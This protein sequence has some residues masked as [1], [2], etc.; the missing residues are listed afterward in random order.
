[1]CAKMAANV[2]CPAMG[3]WRYAW[4]RAAGRQSGQSDRLHTE[5]QTESLADMEAQRAIQS[6]RKPG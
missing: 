4:A 1:M 6:G 5:G 3:P 2:T